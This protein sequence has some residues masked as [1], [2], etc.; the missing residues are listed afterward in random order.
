MVHADGPV[1][2][3]EPPIDRGYPRPGH[4]RLFRARQE[5]AL[6]AGHGPASR[7][8]Q[9]DEGLGDGGDSTVYEHDQLYPAG[10]CASAEPYPLPQYWSA[11]SSGH[12]CYPLCV[13]PARGTIVPGY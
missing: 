12:F 9:L 4:Q 13:F 5:H 6:Q 7:G 10:S 1:E 11:Q 2:W 8:G 3:R